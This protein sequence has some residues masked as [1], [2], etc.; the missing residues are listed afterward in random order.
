MSGLNFLLLRLIIDGLR[1][2]ATA[3]A[4]T[5]ASLMSSY[6]LV[7]HLQLS[8]SL[9]TFGHGIIL[10]IKFQVEKNRKIKTIKN[11]KIVACGWNKKRQT[12]VPSLNPASNYLM[13]PLVTI[14]NFMSAKVLF[15]KLK[16]IDIA[17]L[18]LTSLPG[19]VN[20][21]RD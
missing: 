17:F 14:K 12:Q 18:N 6:K 4:I 15:G 7:K 11:V 21:T 2:L 20:S 5:R 16:R 13:G 10:T 19:F 1:S 9:N 8:C 3:V